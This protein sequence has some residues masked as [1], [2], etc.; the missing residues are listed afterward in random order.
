[1]SASYGPYMQTVNGSARPADLETALQLTYLTFTQPTRDPEGFAALKQRM[2]AFLA[3]RA[4]SP[5][6]VFSDSAAALNGGRFYM[7]RTPTAAEIDAVSLDR[8]LAFH[9]ARFA[10]AADFTFAFAG[11]FD[12]DSIAP[13]LARYLGSLPSTGRRTSAYAAR[14]PRY[15]AANVAL[16]VRKGL[17]PKSRA[18]LTF[19]TSGS[20]LEELDMHRAR[21]CA[22]ILTEH[23]RV[24]LRE[25]MS[26]TYGA[27]ASF[28]ALVPLPGYATMTIGFGCDPAR[29]DTMVSAALAEV[30]GLRDRGPS[31]ADLQK[32][33]EIEHRELEVALQQNGTWTGS[34]LSC[35]Q[36]GI[37]PTRIAHRGERIDLLTVDNLRDTFR[38]YFPLDRRSVITL[39][40][41]T[42]T[43]ASAAPSAP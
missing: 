3:D 5:E 28:N 17:E 24:T 8:V 37:D 26:G 14:G 22:S 23:L 43:G 31:A 13:L 9:R 32:D 11:N 16:Q 1:M 10:N 4:N 40:P 42:T 41:E 27:S 7:D 36:L 30:R 20:P 12:V 33:K 39:L 15:P 19:F 38:K 35:L 18:R 2:R 21:A 6:A 29:V 34:I 25:L